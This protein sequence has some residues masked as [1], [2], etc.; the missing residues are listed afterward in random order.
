MLA[1]AIQPARG[2]VPGADAEVQGLPPLIKNRRVS[3]SR[4]LPVR[5]LSQ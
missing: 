4:P 5:H 3:R 1:R 2:P